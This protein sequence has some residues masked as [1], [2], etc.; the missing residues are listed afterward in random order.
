MWSKIASV[1]LFCGAVLTGVT[2][3]TRAESPAVRMEFQIEKNDLNELIGILILYSHDEQLRLEDVGRNMPQKDSRAI[4]YVN[5]FGDEVFEITATNFLRE[6]QI[7]LFL[8][9]KKNGSR[10]KIAFD[11]LLSLI[12]QRWPDLHEYRGL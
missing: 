9:E 6:D 5:I 7:L 1:L 3:Q 8:Y 12:R 11:L 10:A 4:F 2:V